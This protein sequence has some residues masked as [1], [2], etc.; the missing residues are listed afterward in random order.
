LAIIRFAEKHQNCIKSVDQLFKILD[1]GRGFGFQTSNYSLILRHKYLRNL[2][3]SDKS[4]SFVED[5]SFV[6]RQLRNRH[7]TVN[8]LIFIMKNTF[9]INCYKFRPM[10]AIYRWKLP[11]E[12]RSNICNYH[13]Y[14]RYLFLNILTC[15]NYT[16]FKIHQK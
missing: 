1:V 7:N 8:T 14:V 6:L 4:F 13:Y 9:Y 2:F 3:V 5:N 12:R 15:H 16:I 10:R 11:K